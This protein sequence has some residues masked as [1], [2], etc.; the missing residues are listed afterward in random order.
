MF[1]LDLADHIL[2]T[3]SVSELI[4]K[5]TKANIDKDKKKEFSC[6]F[7]CLPSEMTKTC[8]YYSPISLGKRSSKE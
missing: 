7:F 3:G 4:S 6:I 8:A 2:K 1:R 5:T